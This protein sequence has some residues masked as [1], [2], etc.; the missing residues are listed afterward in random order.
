MRVA[1]THAYRFTAHLPQKVRKILSTAPYGPR[2]EPQ[3]G[4]YGEGQSGIGE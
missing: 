3:E 1:T 2:V 4:E